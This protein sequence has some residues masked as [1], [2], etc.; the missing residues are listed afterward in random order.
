MQRAEGCRPKKGGCRDESGSHVISTSSITICGSED[1][2]PHQG[3]DLP[4]IPP[5][6]VAQ[7]VSAATSVGGW[8]LRA[9][10]AMLV[11]GLTDPVSPGDRSETP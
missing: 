11:G 2:K 1:W 10:L 7:V 4:F 3:W 8:A 5:T 6:L 9:G